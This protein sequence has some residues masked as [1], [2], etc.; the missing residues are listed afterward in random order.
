MTGSLT[1]VLILVIYFVPTIVAFLAG[2]ENKVAIFILNLFLGWS[3]LGW[4]I[5][6]VW[7]VLNQS[8]SRAR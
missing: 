2:H 6:L 3:G 5:A 1:L 7:S 4:V 8:R